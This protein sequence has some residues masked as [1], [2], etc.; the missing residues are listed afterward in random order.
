M[1]ATIS[2]TSGYCILGE[3]SARHDNVNNIHF[4]SLTSLEHIDRQQVASCAGLISDWEVVDADSQDQLLLKAQQKHLTQTCVSLVRLTLLLKE[5]E[6]R[7]AV[8]NEIESFLATH[9][10]DGLY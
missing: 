5:G 2:S 9:N 8:F 10:M 7:N 3:E 6:Y 4:I 1:K